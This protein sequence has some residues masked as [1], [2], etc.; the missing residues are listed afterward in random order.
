MA[1]E[2]K[3]DRIILLLA[4]GL[5]PTAI[6]NKVSCSQPLVY[7]TAK[8]YAVEIARLKNTAPVEGVEQLQPTPEDKPSIIKLP[9]I[10]A[11]KAAAPQLESVAWQVLAAA[12][13]DGDIS[14]KQINAAKEIIKQAARDKTPPPTDRHF[15]FKLDT[16]DI[17]NEGKYQIVDQRVYEVKT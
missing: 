16:I 13:T 15:I 11:N 17:D 1:K 2:S 6:M 10:D 8:K 12:A 14:V 5:H 7:Q 3:T 9:E 4:K